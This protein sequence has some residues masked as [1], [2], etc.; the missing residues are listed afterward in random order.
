VGN[1]IFT[2]FRTKFGFYNYMVMPFAL[3]NAHTTFQQELNP[4]LGPLLSMQLVI[5]TTDTIEDD[6]GIVVV[7]FIYDILI[8]TKLSLEWHHKQV[9]TVLPLLMDNNMC[10][11]I[12]K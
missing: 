12:D 10:V 5:D 3:S 11:E 2:A 6:R 1:E 4:R 9:S 7:S 8:A